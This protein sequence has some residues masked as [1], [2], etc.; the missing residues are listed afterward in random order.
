MIN[1]DWSQLVTKAMKDAAEAARVRAEQVVVEDT[2]RTAE[3]PFIADQLLAIEDD[4]PT[5]LPGTDR[6]WRDY[7]IKVRAWKEGQ[8]DFPDGTK[9][10]SRPS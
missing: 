9:R 8:T 1:I 7:R 3:V 6:Q 5:A 4:D 10:P 2:W